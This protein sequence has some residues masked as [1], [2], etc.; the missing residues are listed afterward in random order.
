MQ[1]LEIDIPGSWLDDADKEWAFGAQRKVDYLCN[2]FYAA[3]AA[4]NLF[5]FLP[6]PQV[7]PVPD[8]NSAIN[9]QQRKRE[10]EREV[11]DDWG[12]PQHDY[13][14]AVILEIERRYKKERW[15]LGFCPG[16]IV[17]HFAGIHAR[18]FVYALDLF[19][20]QLK[21]LA[22][23]SKLSAAFTQALQDFDAAFPELES[24]RDSAHHQDER[25]AG[26]AY[27]KAINLQPV[28]EAGIDASNGVLVPEYV[29]NDAYRITTAAG[30]LGTVNIDDNAVDELHA[31][32]CR[33]LRSLSWTGPSRHL[34]DH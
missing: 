12:L 14:D 34:P 2:Q 28:N 13:S 19:R 24:V 3:L 22:A 25:S 11:R 27:R 6:Y 20:R 10:I 8:V 4:Y 33:A 32:L 5:R 29:S 30:T 17:R 18:A 1:I 21:S 26:L 16:G 31:L 23:D 9:R 7:E 15:A